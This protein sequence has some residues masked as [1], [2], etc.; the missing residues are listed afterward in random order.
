MRRIL[1]VIR[2]SKLD[3]PGVSNRRLDKI[4]SSLASNNY[5]RRIEQ[6]ESRGAPAFLI[7][8]MC[9]RVAADCDSLMI[10]LMQFGC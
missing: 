6:R 10:A 1:A 2:L 8:P 9:S 7:K 5:M 4:S 3:G